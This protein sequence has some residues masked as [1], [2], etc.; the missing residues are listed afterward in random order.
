[1]GISR[2]MMEYEE[3]KNFQSFA[4]LHLLIALNNSFHFNTS[5]TGFCL[6]NYVWTY[7]LYRNDNVLNASFIPC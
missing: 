1:M 5:N 3:N 7:L 4:N 6:L 2:L